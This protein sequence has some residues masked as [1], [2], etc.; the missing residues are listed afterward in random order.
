[1]TNDNPDTLKLAAELLRQLD[2]ANKAGALPDDVRREMQRSALELLR[3]YRHKA[4]KEVAATIVQLQRTFT[5]LDPAQIVFSMGSTS[6][7]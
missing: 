2:E 7:R 5:H 4:L 6:R 1:M 3:L